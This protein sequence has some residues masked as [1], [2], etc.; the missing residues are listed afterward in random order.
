MS[1]GT[2]LVKNLIE[3]EIDA[4]KLVELDPEITTF[5]NKLPH[6]IRGG[7]DPFDPTAPEQWAEISTDI[8]D[9]LIGK[10]LTAG[11]EE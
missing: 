5:L 3:L 2:G 1:P 10:L 6:E 4:E 8:K 9:L 11:T 7:E